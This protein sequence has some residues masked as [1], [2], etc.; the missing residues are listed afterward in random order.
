M[1]LLQAQAITKQFGAKLVLNE[2]SLALNEGERMALVG[3]NGAGKSTLFKILVGELTADSGQISFDPEAA[4]G[5][6]PQENILEE[7][8]T[9]QDYLARAVG[10]LDQLGRTLAE[11]E[12]E[13]GT[14][15]GSALDELL[16]RYGHTQEQFE[17]RGGYD[18][19]Y[20]LD[21]VLAGLN[22]AELERTRPLA[23]LS[24]G[25]RR[26][27]AL[28]GLL[29]QAPALLLLDEPTNHLDF[30]ALAWLETTLATYKGSILLISH[31]RYFLN[32]VVNVIAELHP[33]QREITLYHGNYDFYLQ[34]RERL[35]QKQVA[36][37]EAQQEEIKRLRQLVR[38]Q[39]FARGGGRAPSDGDKLLY[40]AKVAT[41]EKT[42]SAAI[43]DA[44]QRLAD[45][46]AQAIE[47][48]LGR[49]TVNPHFAPAELASQE[50]IRFNGVSKS[51]GA[52]PLIQHLTATIYNGDRVVLVAPNG[53][54]KSTLL[55]LVLGE[56]AADAG[57]ITL[58]PRAMIG[59]LD[60]EQAQLDP[61]HTVLESFSQVTTGS[62]SELRQ[63]LHRSALFA[64][65]EV[66][67]T[68]ASL[69][70]GQRQKLQLARLTAQKANL[71]L[72]DEP[73]NHLDLPSLEQLEEAYRHFAGTILA[74]SHDRWFVE[75]VAT[76]VWRLVDGV[77]VE[78]A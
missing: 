60:Q 47:Q 78:E 50:V 37:Y 44:K 5:Y 70:Q 65:D 38:Q 1:S 33:R 27:V 63:A 48:P 55:K 39:A 35:F 14:A 6:L 73:T 9:V 64:G 71:L 59:Y 41:A 18:L 51:F 21:E 32:R 62:E 25:E 67:Q 68:V 74:V 77:L 46:E 8:L 24:G 4:V 17:R 10:D 61:A 53:T 11:M 42:A 12:A 23:S 13:M 16:T 49:W 3:E 69:S 54:G 34:E 66:W 75:R 15:A 58:A 57:T 22:L 28:A 43:R 40:K 56:L 29:L 45:L 31:D 20:R 7:G 19:D 26:R 2:V 52:R 76:K 72:L 30:E 36:L